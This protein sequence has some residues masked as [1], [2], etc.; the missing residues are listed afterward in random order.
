MVAMALVGAL[1]AD[2]EDGVAAPQKLM[3]D[4][5]SHVVTDGS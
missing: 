4:L 5:V 2:A 3:S 1:T